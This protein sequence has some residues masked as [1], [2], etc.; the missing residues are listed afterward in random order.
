MYKNNNVQIKCEWQHMTRFICKEMN[1]R[2][3]AHDNVSFKYGSQCNKWQTYQLLNQPMTLRIM[4]IVS[5]NS[6]AREMV[7]LL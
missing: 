6:N 2:V 7:S 3:L 4:H 1:H 5:K